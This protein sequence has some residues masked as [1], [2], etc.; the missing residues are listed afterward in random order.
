MDKAPIDAGG[1]KE[2][3]MDRISRIRNEKRRSKEKAGLFI[4]TLL[5]SAGAGTVAFMVAAMVF[6]ADGLVAFLMAY[7]AACMAA[8]INPLWLLGRG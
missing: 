7:V 5:A 8:V 2:D 3:I 4:N 6:Q 1:G